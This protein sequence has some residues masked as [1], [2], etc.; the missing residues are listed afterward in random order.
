[1]IVPISFTFLFHLSLLHVSFI[2]SLVLVQKQLQAY[3]LKKKK[4][5]KTG[6]THV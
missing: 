5:K 1:V 4:K 3:L 6:K 2:I